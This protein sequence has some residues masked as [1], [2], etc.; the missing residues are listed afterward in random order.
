MGCQQVFLDE[1]GEIAAHCVTFYKFSEKPYGENK[2]TISVRM[3][4][5]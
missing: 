5:L 1:F 3:D 2:L 4:F